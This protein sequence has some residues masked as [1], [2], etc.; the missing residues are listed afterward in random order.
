MKER[1]LGKEEQIKALF[2][3]ICICI[4]IIIGPLIFYKLILSFDGYPNPKIFWHYLSV[5]GIGG[6]LGGSTR[7]LLRLIFELNDDGTDPMYYLSRWFLYLVKAFIGIGA[8]ITF[9]IAVNM[10]LVSIQTGNANLNVYGVILSSFIG[11]MFF[12]N[13]FKLLQN[14]LTKPKKNNNNK[15]E[16]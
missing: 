16:K 15:E 5:A 12:E 2:L 4:E 3:A 7:S 13:V 10:G 8:G 14:L 9:F 6:F 11:G 1:I